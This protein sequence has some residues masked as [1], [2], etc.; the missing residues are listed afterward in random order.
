MEQFSNELQQCL[1]HTSKM[2]EYLAL[3]QDMKPPLDN[4]ES[5]DNNLEALKKQLKQLE[6]F[7]LGLAPIAVI[8]RK[9]MKLAEEF[10]KSLPRDFPRGH[11]EKLSI[12]HDSLQNAFSFLSN[13][14]SE[15]MK[16]IM[17]A[18]D[19]EMSKLAVSH[20]EFLHKLKSFSH[21]I[22]EKSKSVKDMET[23]NV[24]DTECIKKTLEVLKNVLK[25]LGHTKMQLETTAFD[26]QFFISEYA[27]DL[28]PDQS[29]QLLRLLNTTQKCF[30]DV[31]ESVTTQVEHLE[32]QLQLEQDLGDQKN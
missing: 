2:Q 16:Q 28:S 6:T 4:Q 22:S 15:R 31:Q 18:I 26:V 3:L 25:D 14:S 1:Q 7:E 24:R 30:L 29:K 27:Q 23:V 12:S 10:L 20:E 9:D 32:T 17:L 19:G 11:L 13:V 21:W 5:L 8:L